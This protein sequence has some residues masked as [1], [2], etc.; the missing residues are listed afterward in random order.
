MTETA[1]SPY[2]AKFQAEIEAEIKANPIIIYAKGTKEAPRCG[3]TMQTVAYFNE[4]G[5][6]FTMQD[7]L[8]NPEKR[9]ALSEMTDWPTLPKVFIGGQFYGDTDILDEMKA[10]GELQTVLAQTFGG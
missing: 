6:P 10:S 4:L 8:D 7:V 3:F 9:Q 5:H 1:T 2:L